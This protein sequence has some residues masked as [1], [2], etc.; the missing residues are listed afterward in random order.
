[1]KQ[2]LILIL[3]VFFSTSTKSQES[4]TNSIGL[5][6]YAGD[7]SLLLEKVYLHTD[8]NYYATGE[9]IWYKAYLVSAEKNCFTAHSNNLYVELISPE[10]EVIHRQN[11]HIFEGRGN[12]D[13]HLDEALNTG[14]YFLRAYT[15]W[16]R[17][18]E[19][20]IYYK[21]IQIVNTSITDKE[22]RTEINYYKAGIDLQFFPE[23]GSLINEVECNIAFKAIDPLGKGVDISGKIVNSSN[24]TLTEFVSSHLGMGKFSFIPKSGESYIANGTTSDGY[25]FSIPLV[26]AMDDGICLNVLYAFE[27]Q[28]IVF[29]KTNQESFKRFEN[30]EFFIKNSCNK[31]FST[32]S[33]K[34]KKLSDTLILPTYEFP[35]GIAK[36]TLIDHNDIPYSERL[37]YLPKFQD[38]KISIK[39]DSQNYAT[40]SKV[41]LDLEITGVDDEETN[42]NISLSAYNQAANMLGDPF[43]S[44]IASY[45][46]IESEVNGYI[47]Q[48]GYYFDPD[49]ENRFEALDLLLMTQGWRD[50]KWKY[51]DEN[52][53]ELS[54]PVEN[55]FSIIE[56]LRLYT[57]SLIDPP[58]E[59]KVSPSYE[60]SLSQAIIDDIREDAFY[61]KMLKTRYGLNDTVVLDE[62]EKVATRIVAEPEDEHIRIYKEPKKSDVYKMTGYE[63]GYPNI[64]EF[65]RGRFAGLEILGREPNIIIQIRGPGSLTQG[66]EPLWL[67]DG[68]P[69][70]RDR[71]MDFPVEELDKVEVLKGADAGIFGLR[72]KNGV[73]SIL[74][75]QAGY[76]LEN[77]EE[78]T[79][80]KKALG[81]YNYFQQRKFYAPEYLVPRTENE[82][83]DLRSTI[84]W[85]PYIYPDENKRAHL[86]FYN[87]DQIT[88]IEIRAE[89]LTDSGIPI[90]G[91]TTYKVN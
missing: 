27:D 73:I 55:E 79:M 39:T 70:E 67:L 86:S 85:E 82:A 3:I 78:N 24:E 23:G 87:S 53:F 58:P 49:N 19:E 56:R 15:N 32:T 30:R 61:K 81:K 62:F 36:L 43:P 46:L 76:G 38:A 54:H 8:R 64:I 1:M 74:S 80:S 31:L 69:V 21:P 34:I 84:F 75:K 65:L 4:Q 50:F 14:T 20:T 71:I 91:K 33:V 18:F 41:E 89:G 57:D 66:S 88:T 9:D 68:M 60:T 51:A 25:I 7:S 16:M 28:I 26:S 59:V 2:K 45:F 17:N 72:G 48:A 37:V 90:T 44:N 40:R 11:I 35:I 5:E 52:D 12:G 10:K 77:L 29:I 22:K 47:E 83:P 42:A 63:L 6:N 13:F